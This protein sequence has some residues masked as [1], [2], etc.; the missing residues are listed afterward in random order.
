MSELLR[1]LRT[2][3]DGIVKPHIEV[4]GPDAPVVKMAL[5]VLAEAEDIEK[6][7]S[8]QKV[9]TDRAHEVTGWARETLCKYAKL[10]VDGKEVPASWAG[11]IVD[12][13]PSGYVFVL[14]SI[15]DNPRLNGQ[16]A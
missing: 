8:A 3:V 5:R 6:S 13:T 2:R 11:L 10:K 15:P 1:E 14:G 4:Y 9:T 12:D 16:A 7:M